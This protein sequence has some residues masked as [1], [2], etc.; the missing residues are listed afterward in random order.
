[1]SDFKTVTAIACWTTWSIEEVAPDGELKHGTVSEETYTRQAR[2]YGRMF[3]ADP[4][5]DHR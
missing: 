2:T 4:R 5:Q 3:V 1:M